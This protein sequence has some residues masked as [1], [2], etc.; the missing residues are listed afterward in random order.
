MTGANW[1]VTNAVTSVV[2]NAPRHENRLTHCNCMLFV[3]VTNVTN[4]NA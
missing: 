1:A 2:T 4:R 3:A